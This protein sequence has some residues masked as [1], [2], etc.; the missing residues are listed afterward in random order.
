MLNTNLFEKNFL[1]S[2]AI[3]E[4]RFLNSV[5]EYIEYN[6]ILYTLAFSCTQS[7]A[8]SFRFR[9]I[10][11]KYFDISICK[12]YLSFAKMLNIV[13]KKSIIVND[14]YIIVSDCRVILSNSICSYA[15]YKYDAN[16]YNHFIKPIEVYKHNTNPILVKL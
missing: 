12:K 13:D 3:Y 15:V 10:W 16:L 8:I 2:N 7:R 14:K 1:Q 5:K 11:T 6:S 4:K 9:E